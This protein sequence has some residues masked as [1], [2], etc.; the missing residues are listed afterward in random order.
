M[1]EVTWKKKQIQTILS[2]THTVAAKL[3]EANTE[4]LELIWFCSDLG[5][6]TKQNKPMGHLMGT[7]W[8]VSHNWSTAFDGHK[9]LQKG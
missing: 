8:N 3:Q 7:W 4:V 2:A 9:T 1:K 5:K 6:K